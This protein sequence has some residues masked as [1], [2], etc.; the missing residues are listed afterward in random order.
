M[1]ILGLREYMT[2]SATLSH[3]SKHK[4]EALI[5]VKNIYLLTLTI[6]LKSH[7]QYC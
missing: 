3:G 6:E 7:K 5:E 1:F 2:W 4:I